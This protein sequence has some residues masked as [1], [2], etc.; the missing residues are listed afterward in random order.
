MMNTTEQ[1]IA[2]VERDVKIIEE[3]HQTLFVLELVNLAP[4]RL[5]GTNLQLNFTREIRRLK[6]VLRVMGAGDEENQ[7]W[8]LPSGL[9]EAGID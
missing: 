5:R 9:G 2:V 6:H 1:F 8:T 7:P 4:V 3:L